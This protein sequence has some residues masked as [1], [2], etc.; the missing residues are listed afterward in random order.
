MHRARSPAV[1]CNGYRRVCLFARRSCLQTCDAQGPHKLRLA[2][3]LRYV[4][5]D[6][7]GRRG[8]LCRPCEQERPD[9]LLYVFPACCPDRQDRGNDGRVRGAAHL[10][11]DRDI[12]Y[13]PGHDSLR[14]ETVIC[15]SFYTGV[16]CGTR[17]HTECHQCRMPLRLVAVDG[18]L[19]SVP[20]L[21]GELYGALR[22][23][24]PDHPVLHH[25]S[26]AHDAA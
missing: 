7:P 18:R 9:I 21:C 10:E 23:V 11:F 6:K 15:R 24:P 4:D 25:R 17:C 19:C 16:L 3:H 22:C 12:P 5:A 13:L 14:E 2:C 1:I 20:L 26:A 8:I